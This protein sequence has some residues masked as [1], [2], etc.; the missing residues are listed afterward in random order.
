M[1]ERSKT[2][3][4]QIIKEYIKTATPVGSRCLEALNQKPR[5]GSGQAKSRLGV[6]SATIRNEMAVLEKEGYIAQPHT[7]AGRV[8]TEK[9]YQF[10]LEHC[11]P[12]K[13]SDKEAK[14]INELLKQ[15][16]A[17]Q[18]ELKIKE[19]AKKIAGFSQSAVLIG[20]SDDDF[21]YTGL[22]NL[23][24]QPEFKDPELI[25]DLGLVI[26]HLDQ[27]MSK[28]FEQINGLRVL[29]GSQNPFGR[30]CSVVLS[31]WQV[32]RQTGVVGILGPMRMDYEKNLG[33]LNFIKE[34]I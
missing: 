18:L 10:F 4:G 31:T 7:S 6:S 16:N 29:V 12:G 5:F 20:F 23:F 8:P 25:Y 32:S 19:L 34:N 3:L 17:V 15:S 13:V 1:E 2:L 33:L 26:D 30:Q 21:Y 9:G 14:E 28:I 11:Q 27:A 22:S 24:A